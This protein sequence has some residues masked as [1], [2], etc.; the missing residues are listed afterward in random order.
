MSEHAHSMITAI[1][2]DT[3]RPRLSAKRRGPSRSSWDGYR[4]T[5]DLRGISNEH[6]KNHQPVIVL[7]MGNRS[8]A[9]ST[10]N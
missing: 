4:N 5:R 2:I 7:R 1:I 8:F 6:R 10:S 3:R 9:L